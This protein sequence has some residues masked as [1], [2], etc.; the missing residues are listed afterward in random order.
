MTEAGRAF[1]EAAKPLYGPRSVPVGD[2]N[3]PV[4]TC[5]TRRDSHEFSFSEHR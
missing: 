4:N 3:D 5:A 2:S 1:F